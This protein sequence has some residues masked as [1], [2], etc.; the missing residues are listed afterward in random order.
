MRRHVSNCFVALDADG[1]MPAITPS[2]QQA[3]PSLNCRPNKQDA[4]SLSFVAGMSRRPACGG[5]AI[6]RARSWRHAVNDAIARASRAEP[7]IFALVVDAKDEVALRFYEHL[8]PDLAH[9][10]APRTS[11]R[12]ARSQIAEAN[13]DPEPRPRYLLCLSLAS[14]TPGRNGRRTKRQAERHRARRRTRNRWRYARY[15]FADYA[16][17]FERSRS[18]KSKSRCRSNGISG[19]M[20]IPPGSSSPKAMNLSGPAMIC[21]NFSTATVTTTASCRRDSSI[22]CSGL[23]RT[24]IDRAGAAL[25]PREWYGE[26]VPTQRFLPR[27]QSGLCANLNCHFDQQVA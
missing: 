12:A 10:S 3:F 20:T 24:G 13:A 9:G 22:R 8:D 14:R 15:R 7:A 18:R 26:T 23:L 6:S 25:A 1:K 5:P 11:R 4:A 16:H 17:R 27:D 2:R 21:E 19:S